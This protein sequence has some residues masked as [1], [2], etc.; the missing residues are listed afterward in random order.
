M[1]VRADYIGPHPRACLRPSLDKG[2]L[3]S[4]PGSGSPTRTLQQSAG[5]SVQLPQLRL[6][7]AVVAVAWRQ[8]LHMIAP[9][10]AGTASQVQAG[11]SHW[12]AATFWPAAGPTSESGK[13]DWERRT[14]ITGGLGGG[15]K[16]LIVA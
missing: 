16:L 13:L 9:V 11:V 15:Y 10:A 4:R 6:R 1:L 5:D 7:P 8:L 2:L 3:R 14:G 12:Q